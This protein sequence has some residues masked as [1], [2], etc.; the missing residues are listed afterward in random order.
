M[1]AAEIRAIE[2]RKI[3]SPPRK[4]QVGMGRKPKSRWQ[5]PIVVGVVL[6]VLVLLCIVLALL[7]A[8]FLPTGGSL[9]GSQ[10]SIVSSPI[11][12]ARVEHSLEWKVDNRNEDLSLNFAP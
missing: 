11:P 4:P 12:T 5:G 6:V 1:T 10:T 8:V 2:A 3:T 9:G 7:P